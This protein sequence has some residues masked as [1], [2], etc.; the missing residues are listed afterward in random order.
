MKSFIPEI[1]NASDFK[2]NFGMMSHDIDVNTLIG[3]LVYTSTLIQEINKELNTD[4][5]IEIKIK[6]LDKGSFEVH[7]QL[8]ESVLESL[9]NRNNIEYGAALIGTLGGLY[10]FVKFLKGK[11]PKSV[12][13]NTGNEITIINDEGQT[14]VL[15]QSIVNIYNNNSNV[16]NT[17]AKQFNTLE[18]SEDIQSFEIKNWKD[19]TIAKI[20]SSE[21]R[22]LAINFVDEVRELTEV[23]TLT[24][25]KLSI[26]RP[27]FSKDLKWDLVYKGIKI[28]AFLK[29]EALLKMVDNGD[30][31]AK[32]D[33]M[34]ADLEVTKFYDPDLKTYMITKDSYK[35]SRF[36]EHIKI[37]KI[38]S[39]F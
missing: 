13:E 23:E 22:E 9:F 31:F 20:P 1:M 3:S 2:L 38:G 17:I 35:I 18:K 25:E 10:E 11:K 14:L 19:E 5:K 37:G 15:S 30:N 8:I 32:G 36:I 21:F 28:S 12:V 16:R 26:I 39:I 4:R 7:I 6:A 29:D 33:L 34:V 24:G 27:S